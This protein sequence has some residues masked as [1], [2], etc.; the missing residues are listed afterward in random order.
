MI[1]LSIG[2]TGNWSLKVLSSVL[3]LFAMGCSAPKEPPDPMKQGRKIYMSRCA[4]CHQADGRGMLG[5]R[6]FAADL[7]SGPLDQPD[8]TLIQIIMEGKV[9]ERGRMPAFKPILSDADA[10]AVLTFMRKTLVPDGNRRAEP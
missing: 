3:L 8:E 7:T 9:S 4:T 6:Q 2:P 5:N 10:H 1:Y